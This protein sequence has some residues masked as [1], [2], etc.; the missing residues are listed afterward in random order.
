[1][2]RIVGNECRSARGIPRL[3]TLV[4]DLRYA[5]RMLVKNPGFTVVAVLTLALAVT[6]SLLPTLGI[7]STL[8]RGFSAEDDLPR[9]TPTLPLNDF[10]AGRSNPPQKSN[11]YREDPLCRL[12]APS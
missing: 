9:A 6:S 7:E 8:G 3:E 5:S 11:P 2:S 4:R 1:M 12:L 10:G